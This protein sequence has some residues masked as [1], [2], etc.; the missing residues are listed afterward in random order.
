MEYLDALDEL[1]AGEY[2]AFEGYQ[3][4]STAKRVA[5]EAFFWSVLDEDA[6]FG[7]NKGH[8]SISDFTSWRKTHPKG[9]VFE[10]LKTIFEESL[11]D[12]NPFLDA[13][14]GEIEFE[15]LLIENKGEE[16]PP[17][18]ELDFYNQIIGTG[19]CQLVFDGA[20][21]EEVKKVLINVIYRK[22]DLRFV[23]LFC[24]YP[25]AEDEQKIF[26]KKRNILNEIVRSSPSSLP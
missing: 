4:H 17:L 11:M 7:N 3:I 19:F 26:D 16:G 12:I 1:S 5:K 22:F 25:I 6:P 13:V 15:Q 18:F 14:L 21:G 10:Y 2:F 9:L 8:F 23:Q 20:L 24:N